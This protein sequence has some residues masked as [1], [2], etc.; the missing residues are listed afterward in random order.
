MVIRPDGLGEAGVFH[1][2][3]CRLSDFAAVGQLE[4]DD[5]GEEQDHE[6][7]AQLVERRV[8]CHSPLRTMAGVFSIGR[9]AAIGLSGAALVLAGCG[10]HSPAT[11]RS[12]ASTPQPSITTS[13]AADLP[14]PGVRCPGPDAPATTLYFPSRSGARLDGALVGSGPVGAVLLSEY[15]GPYCGWWAYA[16]DLAR[17]G[18]HVLLFDFH[19]Q[20]L[21]ACD[22]HRLAYVAD[23]AG[24]IA[25]LRAHGARSIALIGA[26]LGGAV[27]LAAAASQHPAALI[28]LS[29][30]SDPGRIIRGLH[31]NGPHF[32]PRVHTP[33]LFAVARR[34]T[35][36]TV[37]AMRRIY[38]ATAS[39]AKTLHILPR[40]AGHGWDMLTSPTGGFTPLARQIIAFVKTH[41]TTTQ[42]H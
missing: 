17:H 23:A 5:R 38:D 25:T 3:C 10:S 35:Y 14:Q 12:T 1:C 40:S 34:D 9:F 6:R 29:G 8:L 21:S 31:L 28:D 11:T 4:Q 19:C 26:S 22:H 27:A 18:I 20:G 15:P 2:R 16:V 36:V 32:A 37:D 24:A 13:A 7:R 41:P 30:E 33:S 39:R 42:Q